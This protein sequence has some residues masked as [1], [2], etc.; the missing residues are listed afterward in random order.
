LFPANLVRVNLLRQL[1]NQW[2]GGL[3]MTRT[4]LE[5]ALT[6]IID[7]ESK[8][9]IRWWPGAEMAPI[10]VRRWSSFRRRHRTKRPTV[11]DRVLDLAKGL[12]A[13]FEPDIPH[14]PLSEWLYLARI[15]A[16]VL[17]SGS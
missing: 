3:E 1:S 11:E 15:L 8:I 7:A 14:T 9:G 17:E 10:V 6:A 5:L 4:E 12:Q 2:V 13:H 16:Q